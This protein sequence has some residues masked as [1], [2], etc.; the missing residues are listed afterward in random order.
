MNRPTLSVVMPNYNHAKFLPRA[1]DSLLGQTRPPDE[2]L[3]LDDGSTDDSRAILERVAGR[4]PL[5]RP[6]FPCPVYG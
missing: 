2:I 1:L 3:V 6:F 5:I 4:E